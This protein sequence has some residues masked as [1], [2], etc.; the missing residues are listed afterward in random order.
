M[1]FAAISRSRSGNASTVLAI[2]RWRHSPAMPIAPS[3]M[4]KSPLASLENVPRRS[5]SVNVS[6]IEVIRTTTSSDRATADATSARNVRVVESLISSAWSARLT[7][8][9]RRL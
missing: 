1:N 6:W 5:S 8:G 3:S 7:G 4:M 9:L 2:V